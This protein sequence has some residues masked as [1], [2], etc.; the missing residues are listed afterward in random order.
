MYFCVYP[1]ARSTRGRFLARSERSLE[2]A[3]VK[4]F[5]ATPA[6]TPNPPGSGFRGFFIAGAALHE[7]LLLSA[8]CGGRIARWLVTVRVASNESSSIWP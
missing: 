8:V 6:C 5:Q 4:F 1:E 2:G 7:C 3:L